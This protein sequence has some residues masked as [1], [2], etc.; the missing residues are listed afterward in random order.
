M[1]QK[2]TAAVHGR[3]V[4]GDGFTIRFRAVSPTDGTD[5]T[6]VVVSNVNVDGDDAGSGNVT[7]ANPIL[8]GVNT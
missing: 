1:A 6:G 5:V 7:V 8:I 4:V 2:V 3:I